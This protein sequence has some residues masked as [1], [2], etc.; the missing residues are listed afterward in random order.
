MF[1]D[2]LASELS[3]LHGPLTDIRR[4]IHQHPELGFEEVRTQKLVREWLTQRGY[5]PRDCAG[6]GL[7]ADLHP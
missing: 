5:A 6:T 3:S 7:V 4:D 1:W 2:N